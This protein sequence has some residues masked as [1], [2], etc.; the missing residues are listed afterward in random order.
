MIIYEK[1]EQHLTLREETWLINH[2]IISENDDSN[3][4]LKRKKDP[5]F[6]FSYFLSEVHLD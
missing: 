6:P 5:V 4:S 2:Q 3:Q 1:I